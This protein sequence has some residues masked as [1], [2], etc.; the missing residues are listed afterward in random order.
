MSDNAN[1]GRIDDYLAGIDTAEGW[2]PE[3]AGWDGFPPSYDE[4]NARRLVNGE[5]ARS[6]T[7]YLAAIKEGRDEH[8]AL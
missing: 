3:A 5:T 8:D 4:W 2:T 1:D 6:F 7:E